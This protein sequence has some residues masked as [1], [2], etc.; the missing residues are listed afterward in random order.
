MG[1][2]DECVVTVIDLK[3]DQ[4]TVYTE[5]Y[6]F[7]EEA[8]VSWEFSEAKDK[9]SYRRNAFNN[10]AEGTLRVN[11]A[12]IPKPTA[13]YEENETVKKIKEGITR[14]EAFEFV[15]QYRGHANGVLLYH[16]VIPEY[17][18]CIEKTIEPK[19]MKYQ[20]I[21]RVKRQSITW[22]PTEDIFRLVVRFLGPNI[23]DFNKNRMKKRSRVT[24]PQIAH[25]GYREAK[26]FLA[27]VTA[28]IVSSQFPK[29]EFAEA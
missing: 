18:N 17:C 22:I 24:P 10:L 23:S 5:V 7:K 15:T 3:N 28:R 25:K 9:S 11:L 1:W 12:Q 2:F 20:I 29:P 26:D 16:L 13:G 6:R 14:K 8:F 21:T 4:P 27:D 19:D